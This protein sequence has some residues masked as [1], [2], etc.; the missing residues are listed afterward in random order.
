[1]LKS[2][3]QAAAGMVLVL[4]IV[5]FWGIEAQAAVPLYINPETDYV[6]IVEDDADLLTDVEEELLAEEMEAIT[7]WGNVG[8]KSIDDNST[9]AEN[10]LDFYYWELF[11]EES[12]IVF[13]IDMDNRMLWIKCDGKIS[14]IVTDAYCDTIADN[15][16]RYA[17]REDY[18]GCAQRVYRQAVSLMSGRSIA[19]PM[20]YI[21]N[22]LLAV[23]AALLLNYWIMR[24]M[25]KNSMPTQK[26]WLRNVN[27]H[28]SL[29]NTRAD[30][31]NTTKTY[32]PP[33]S[34]SSGGS[35]GGGG[36]GGGSRGG[37]SSG[38]HRF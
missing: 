37:G 25:A 32:D 30:Y 16:Y 14:K 20:K 9:T 26:D 18:Y 6:V 24:R 15:V 19:M 13:L 36:G 4:S 22:A 2:W 38:G 8:F 3:K 5:C 29:T 7:K 21:S 12:G 28:Y 11:Q 35:S 23:I 17:S 10:Y 34:S 1:M 27:S 33:S 31:I